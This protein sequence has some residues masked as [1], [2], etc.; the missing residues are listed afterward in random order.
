[1]F[2]MVHIVFIIQYKVKYRNVQFVQN[3]SCCN[4]AACSATP[5]RQ[6]FLTQTGENLPN[7]GS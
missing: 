4:A 6:R 7:T 1:M 5:F 2:E 3:R